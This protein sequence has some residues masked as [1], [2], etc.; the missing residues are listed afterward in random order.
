MGEEIQ[1]GEEDTGWR[2]AIPEAR[3][4]LQS[5]VLVGVVGTLLFLA[6]FSILR[7]AYHL[8][9]TGK[10]DELP[11]IATIIGI[12]IVFALLVFALRAATLAGALSGGMIC[13]ILLSGTSSR[14]TP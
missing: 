14:D 10:T 5:R 11:T 12:S 13:L 3:D 6:A 9:D 2:K 1:G 7:Q 4:R 8:W